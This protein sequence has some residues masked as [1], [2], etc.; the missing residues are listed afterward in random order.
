[1]LRRT[2]NPESIPADAYNWGSQE[3]QP[4]SFDPIHRIQKPSDDC[5]GEV[6]SNPGSID[7]CL[8]LFAN[9]SSTAPAPCP[10]PRLVIPNKTGECRVLAVRGVPSPPQ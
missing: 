10:L 8:I 5:Q 7:S 9:Y 3:S 4:H 6:Y 2:V 1:M